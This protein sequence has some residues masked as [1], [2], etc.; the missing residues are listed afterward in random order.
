MSSKLRIELSCAIRAYPVAEDG[1]GMFSDILFKSLPG[2]IVI[3][4]A[5]AVHADGDDPL[6]ALDT[7]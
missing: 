1:I 3:S 2:V 4:N 6:Q 7:G 5:L